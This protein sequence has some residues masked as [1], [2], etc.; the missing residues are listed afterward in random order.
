MLLIAGLLEGFARQLVNS[1]FL[2]YGIGLSLL[3][4]WCAY[5]YLPRNL[6]HPHS[7]KDTP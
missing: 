7:P 3:A 5:F 4:M 2:R 6:S 1:D